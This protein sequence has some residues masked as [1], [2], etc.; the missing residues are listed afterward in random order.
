VRVDICVM[1]ARQPFDPELD[2]CIRHAG[3][4][5]AHAAPALHYIFVAQSHSAG[6]VW[7][8]SRWHGTGIWCPLRARERGVRGPRR[9]PPVEVFAVVRVCLALQCCLRARL[10]CNSGALVRL[11][12]CVGIPV[13]GLPMVSSF[14]KLKVEVAQ[15]TVS[16]RPLLWH[17][18]N[19]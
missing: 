9:V 17:R 15:P 19:R 1:P 12:Q 7:T 10:C 2:P 5:V 4:V 13:S 11:R 8:L 16:V 6:R 18:A 3:G 14:G